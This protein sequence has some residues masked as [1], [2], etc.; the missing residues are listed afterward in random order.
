MAESVSE[1]GSILFFSRFNI[2]FIVPSPSSA[3]HTWI[4]QFWNDQTQD[5]RETESENK[6]V[7]WMSILAAK[8]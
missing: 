3:F 8:Q 6:A 7:D 1:N 4:W 2:P 5:I